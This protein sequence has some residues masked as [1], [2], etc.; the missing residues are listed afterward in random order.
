M[1]DFSKYKTKDEDVIVKVVST[2]TI[3]SQGVANGRNVPVVIVE[4]DTDGY[5]NKMISI[6]ET[7]NSGFFNSQWAVS[8]DNSNVMLFLSFSSPIEKKII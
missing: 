7:V 4:P 2:A 3:A 6:H 8:R 1:H 5:I